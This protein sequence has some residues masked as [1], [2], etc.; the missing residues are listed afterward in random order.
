VTNCI[1]ELHF[2]SPWHVVV[3]VVVPLFWEWFVFCG[4]NVASRLLLWSDVPPSVVLLSFAPSEVK[5]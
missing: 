3:V 2:F 5:L 1:A 4:A